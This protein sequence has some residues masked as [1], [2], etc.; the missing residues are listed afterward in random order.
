[1]SS[2]ATGTEDD[3]GPDIE[4]LFIEHLTVEP[5]KN[6]RLVRVSFDSPDPEEAAAIA[7]SLAEN[8]VSTTL[9]RRYD[10]ASYAK[11]FLEERIELVR[12]N[13]EDSERRLID[14]AREREIINLD[15]KLDILMTR[16]KEMSSQQVAAEAQRISAEADYQQMS[17]E[18]SGRTTEVLES[19]VIQKLKDRQAELEAEYQEQLKVFKPGYPKMQQLAQQIADIKRTIGEESATIGSATR[20]TYE[21]KLNQEAKLAATI[22][23]IKSEILALQDRSTDYQTMK[24]EVDTNREL[25]DGLLQR[26]KEVGVV[27]G[28]GTNNISVVDAAEV[29]REK[30]S[31]SLKKNLA[32]ALALGLFGGIALAFLLETLDDSIK[33]T[34]DVERRI[35]APILGLVPWVSGRDGP[36][37]PEQLGLWVHEDPKSAMA[38]AYRSLRTSLIFATSEGAPRLMHFT[39][40]SASEGKTTSACSTAITFAQT[41]SK[42][43]LIDCD[44]RNPSLHKEFGLPNAKGLTHFLTGA[45]DPAEIALPSPVTR[46]FVVTSGPIPPNPVELLA[47]A[48]MMELLELARERFDYVILD[49]PPV[50]GLADAIVLANLARSTILVVESQGT[51]AGALEGSAKRLRAAGANILGAILVK[52]GQGW[53]WLRVWLRLPLL[54]QLWRRPSHPARPA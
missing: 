17:K 18:G 47:G 32:I 49:G 29:P 48:R 4:G 13:L 22:N 40:A 51:R 11:T 1:M 42:V 33:S 35:D 27:A 5:V 14:Y 41:G 9:E 46:L 16:L 43:L 34:D 23:A 20:A 6:S 7:N 25:Y 26:M 12:A 45:S 19:P 52:H 8:Y 15:D 53:R 2:E 24:R 54:V 3:L 31:P 30:F 50:L 10:A 28:I 36:K 37:N 21:A 44:L 38:E 39:S